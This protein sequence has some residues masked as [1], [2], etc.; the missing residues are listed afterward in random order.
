MDGLEF[1]DK[2]NFL[3]AGIAYSD[4]ITTVSPTY[5]KEILTQEFGCGLDGFLG[6]YKDKLS[7]ILNGLDTTVFNPKND[8][9]LYFQFDLKTINN[10]NEN[11]KAFLKST[12]LKGHNTPLLVMVTRLVEQKG[13]DLLI[14][15]LT[16]LLS[17][18]LNLFIVGEG[19]SEFVKILDK[20]SKKYKVIPLK[21]R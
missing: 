12:T 14:E 6:Y 4:K 2:L 5:A 7:G 11:K 17:K 15:S 16:E 13:I 8:E 18:K 19:N 20:Y 1:Y 9:D 3:K 21:Y 10:K